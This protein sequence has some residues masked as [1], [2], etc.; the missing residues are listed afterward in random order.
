M[1]DEKK[2]VNTFFSIT[3]RSIALKYNLL[4]HFQSDTTNQHFG[5]KVIKF[6]KEAFYCKICLRCIHSL[7]QHSCVT[8]VSITIYRSST[9]RT[10]HQVHFLAVPQ[11]SSRRR[12]WNTATATYPNAAAVDYERSFRQHY[13]ITTLCYIWF[14][15]GGRQSKMAANSKYHASSKWHTTSPR[16]I[17]AI[18]EMTHGIKELTLLWYHK[19]YPPNGKQESSHLFSNSAN[20]R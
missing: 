3:S 19:N 20:Y 10:A 9:Q 15:W 6:Y 14:R 8:D 1:Y 4:N 7:L 2:K 17:H 5:S 11:C 18:W 12:D 16:G 13:I